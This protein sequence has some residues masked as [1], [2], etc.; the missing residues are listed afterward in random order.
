MGSANA[1]FH[2]RGTDGCPR[3]TNHSRRMKPPRTGGG[4][5]IEALANDRYECGR[6]QGITGLTT[7]I[8]ALRLRSSIADCQLCEL[9]DISCSIHF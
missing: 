4:I 2:G 5:N 1:K 3:L 7:S 8:S 9:P 6:G